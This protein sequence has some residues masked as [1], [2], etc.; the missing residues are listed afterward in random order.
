MIFLFGRLFRQAI[1]F[2]LACICVMSFGTTGLA[3]EA[4]EEMVSVQGIGYPPIRAESPAQAHL[5]AKRAAI[6]NA[7][8]NALSAKTASGNGGDVT[9]Q[10]LSGFVSGLT[11]VEEEY[12]KDGGI[13]ITAKVPKKNIAVSSGRRTEVGTEGRRA[14]R[15]GGPERVSLDEWYKII[16]NLVRIDK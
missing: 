3:D 1:L 15:S 4:A 10:E 9:Y 13:R 5:M 8:R 6:V 14:E 2:F 7:Y 16:D 11:I 12:L